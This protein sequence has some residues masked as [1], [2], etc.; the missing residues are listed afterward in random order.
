ML[1]HAVVSPTGYRPV[2][3]FGHSTSRARCGPRRLACSRRPRTEGPARQRSPHASSSPQAP[4]RHSALCLHAWVTADGNALDDAA[5][6]RELTRRRD[7]IATV[8]WIMRCCNYIIDSITM[9]HVRGRRPLLLGLLLLTVGCL[10]V[11]AYASPPDPLWVPGVYDA[12]DYDDVIATVL[13]LDG[14]QAAAVPAIAPSARIVASA[15]APTPAAPPA[16]LHAT[17]QS[18]APPAR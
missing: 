1:P 8:R 15:F 12:A 2:G 16:P 10:R 6:H 7:L 18:R 9:P 11:V 17:A 14:L 3:T 13:S 5:L 4:R